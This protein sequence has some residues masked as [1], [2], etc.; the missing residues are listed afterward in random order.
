MQMRKRES[1][2]GRVLV[3]AIMYMAGVPL[4]LVVILWFFFFRG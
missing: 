1:Q 3:P 4:G 2:R